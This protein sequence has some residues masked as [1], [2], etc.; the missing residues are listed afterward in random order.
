MIRPYTTG[1]LPGSIR[2]PEAAAK[3]SSQESA[4]LIGQA[5]LALIIVVENQPLVGPAVT[6]Y[7]TAIR[8]NGEEAAAN[9]GREAM[10]ATLR[11][12]MDADPGHAQRCQS[13]IDKAW[14]GLAGWRA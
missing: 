4:D 2:Q 14:A 3:P 1:H 13:I 7:Q 9:G 8:H 12:V 6:A 5:L 11:F 10:D